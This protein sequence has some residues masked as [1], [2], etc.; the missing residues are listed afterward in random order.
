MS[1]GHPH[2]R[3]IEKHAADL[4]KV[5]AEADVKSLLASKPR[6]DKTYDLPFLSGHSKNGRTIYIDR[7]FPSQL[8]IGGY[9]IPAESFLI[10]HELIEKSL[11]DGIGCDYHTAHEFATVA[12]YVRA[13]AAGITPEQYDDAV[14]QF[15][16]AYEIERLVRIPPDLDLAPYNDEQDEPVLLHLLSFVETDGDQPDAVVSHEDG[17]GEETAKSYQTSL[18][19]NPFW[20][21]RASTRDGRQ[22]I[23]ELADEKA[24]TLDSDVCQ[25][26]RADLTNPRARLSAEVSWLP[27]ISPNRALQIAAALCEGPASPVLD[28]GL[29]PLARANILSAT[30][31]V[32]PIETPPKELTER[33]LALANS[34]EEIDV[35]AVLVQVNEERSIAMFPPVKGESLIEEELMAKRREYRNGIK[36]FLNRLPTTTLLIVV[37]GV[38]DR[39]TG[40]GAHHAPHLI[41]DLVNAYEVEAQGFIQA[42]AKNLDGLIEKARLVVE[43]GE[44]AVES[45]IEAI[46]RV[47]E[48]W[49]RVVSPIQ[50]VAKTRGVDHLESRR[51]AIQIR[52]LGVDLHNQ[53]QMLTAAKK[54]TE[55]LKTSFS[56]LPEFSDLVADD[57]IFIEQALKERSRSEEQ[58]KEWEREITYAAEIGIVSKDVLKIS[59]NGIQWGSR[60]YPLDSITRI[61]WGGISHSIN[62]IPTGTRYEIY[63]GNLDSDTVINLRRADVYSTF[64]DKL[65]RAV[66]V[67]LLLEHVSRLKQGEKI[68]FGDATIEDDG[69]VL[70]R[71]RMFRSSEP[72]RLTWH[73]TKIWSADGSFVIGSKD[74]R[75]VY[76]ALPY[77][78]ISNVHV[79]ENMIRAFFNTR[80]LRISSLFS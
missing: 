33:I 9:D 64:V 61:R 20:I 28:A 2:R 51:F 63:V 71:H 7:H 65:W 74:D 30:F 52:S 54:I 34:A 25:R 67:R 46:R 12:E 36:E 29:P 55:I 76:V 45:A 58:R 16:K 44:P 68:R 77:L 35:G 79:L 5:L 78:Q 17:A 4:V 53:H 3:P 50:V 8:T 32:M 39:A 70:L 14:R 26:A 47:A 72:V 43:Q 56:I 40:V 22:R 27:G 21:L 60:I 1:A 6:V 11:I 37:N 75:N 42:E 48:N 66:G 10:T 59:P 41:E 80:H 73:Q 18:H 49:I 69:V 24:L 57:A 15:V 38:V 23:V 19:K 31:D 13:R 62:G